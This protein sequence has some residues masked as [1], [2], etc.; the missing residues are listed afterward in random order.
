MSYYSTIIG[1]F[2]YE[3]AERANELFNLTSHLFAGGVEQDGDIIRIGHS[4]TNNFRNLG[5]R[6]DDF[7]GPAEAVACVEVTT[8]GAFEG[9]IIGTLSDKT[10]DLDE[11]AERNTDTERPNGDDYDTQE[12]FYDALTSYEMEVSE[13]FFDSHPTTLEEL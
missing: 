11:W 8:D 13:A 3:S 10:V 2:Q 9:Y 6:I 5:R 7:S 4:E 1:E 12:L